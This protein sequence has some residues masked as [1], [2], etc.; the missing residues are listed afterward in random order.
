MRRQRDPD[1]VILYGTS[2]GNRTYGL[3]HLEHFTLSEHAVHF[4]RFDLCRA[5]QNRVKAIDGW[6]I[7]LQLENEAVELRFGQRVCPFH[8]ERIL[9]CQY[10]ERRIQFVRSLPHRHAAFFHGF[11][12]CRLRFWSGTIDFIRQQDV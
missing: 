6:V 12:Q 9:C 3:A 10:E 5:V 1:R 4:W 8:F 11:Q 7:D 2:N